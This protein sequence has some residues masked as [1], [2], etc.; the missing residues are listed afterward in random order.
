MNQK[1]YNE[2]MAR[3]KARQGATIGQRV[4][5]D[6][7]NIGPIEEF[8]RGIGRG[9]VKSAAA[10]GPGLIDL[11]Y[12]QMGAAGNKVQSK[13]AELLG[14][15]PEEPVYNKDRTPS[16]FSP[17]G[18]SR[19]ILEKTDK[20]TDSGFLKGSD[21]V[22]K[23]AFGEGNAGVKDPQW[24]IGNL[25]EMAPATVTIAG[26]TRRAITRNGQKHLATLGSRTATEAAKKKAKKEIQ[27]I[28]RNAAIGSSVVL[29][30]AMQHDEYRKWEKE[31]PESATAIGDAVATMFGA[32]SGILEGIG[33]GMIMSFPFI[34]KFGKTAGPKASANFWKEFAKAAPRS[35]AIEGGTE[36][37]QQIIQNIGKGLGYDFDTEITEGI[38]E[39][40]ILGAAVGGVFSGFEAQQA[41]SPKSQTEAD[42]MRVNKA[43]NRLKTVKKDIAKY[44]AALDKAKP[45]SWAHTRAE[46][47]MDRALAELTKQE[48]I[49]ERVAKR[50]KSED[51]IDTTMPTDEEAFGTTVDPSLTIEEVAEGIDEG[52]ISIEDW[53]K[54]P[55][56]KYTAEEIQI[57]DEHVADLKNQQD[58]DALARGEEVEAEV[59]MT[60]PGSTV[61]LDGTSNDSPFTQLPEEYT[62]EE[63]ID[64]IQKD[65]EIILEG[66]QDQIPN[67]SLSE[68][69]LPEPVQQLADLFGIRVVYTKLDAKPGAINPGGMKSLVD[70]KL[71]YINELSSKPEQFLFG[72]E[73][74]HSLEETNPAAYNAL[75]NAAVPMMKRSELDKYKGKLDKRG[76][77]ITTDRDAAKEMLG[78][79]V[80]DKFSDRKFWDKVYKQNPSKFKQIINSIREF[81]AKIAANF[82]GVSP[83]SD[84]FYNDIMALEGV[85]VDVLNEHVGYT[86]AVEAVSNSSVQ[87]GEATDQNL[88]NKHL[89]H[90]KIGENGQILMREDK[91]TI[92]ITRLARAGARTVGDISNTL[93]KEGKGAP[94]AVLNELKKY[95][96]STGKKI[97]VKAEGHPYFTKQGFEQDGSSMVW[98]AK[99][100]EG[101]GEVAADT[102]VAAEK[103]AKAEAPVSKKDAEIAR[104]MDEAELLKSNR[105]IRELNKKI[106][107]ELEVAR[108]GNK[109]EIA[110]A[111]EQHDKFA[112]RKKELETRVAEIETKR[113]ADDKQAREQVSRDRQKRE[114][115]ARDARDAAKGKKADR[116]NRNKQSKKKETGESIAEA[117]S[118]S[119]GSTVT[120]TGKQGG[121]GPV[122]DTFLFNVTANGK[123]ATFSVQELTNKAV[124]EAAIAKQEEFAAKKDTRTLSEKVKGVKR[125]EGYKETGGVTAEL[126]RIVDSLADA[127]K[128]GDMAAFA[129][130][131]ADSP[132]EMNIASE[133]IAFANAVAKHMFAGEPNDG[134]PAVKKIPEGVKGK[135]TK[136]RPKRTKEEQ[137]KLNVLT[138]EL[139]SSKHVERKDINQKD[140]D[141][142]KKEVDL[143]I[144]DIDN[145]KTFN[146]EMEDE[147]TTLMD[148]L[149]FSLDKKRKDPSFKKWFKGGVVKTGTWDG[150]E[151][152]M[153]YHGA[154][155]DRQNWTKDE[156]AF[157]F[158]TSPAISDVYSAMFTNRYD[159]LS[160]GPDNPDF[161]GMAD[162]LMVDYGY[163]G[164]A[165]GTGAKTVPAY[166]NI[167]NPLVL[168]YPIG[169][170]DNVWGDDSVIKMARDRGNDGI[171]SID[172]ES[173]HLDEAHS[174]SPEAAEANL[175][176]DEDYERGYVI[177]NDHEVSTE[178][179]LKAF[180]ES[181]TNDL[182]RTQTSNHVVIV[183]DPKKVRPAFDKELKFSLDP[184]KE[185]SNA[186]ERFEKKRKEFKKNQKKVS[187]DDP[188]AVQKV[189]STH[190][191]PE[192]NIQKFASGRA[193]WLDKNPMAG[194]VSEDF[195]SDFADREHLTTDQETDAKF[196]QYKWVRSET[197]PNA[198]MKAVADFFGVKIVPYDILPESDMKYSG[199]SIQ[200]HED[201]VYL[202]SNIVNNE[203]GMHVFGHEFLHNLSRSDHEAYKEFR[204]E[205]VKY[206]TV[207]ELID[208]REHRSD[209]ETLDIDR[210]MDEI[211]ADKAGDL[212]ID[213]KFWDKLNKS[214][215]S[216]F[217]KI[218]NVLK[219]LLTAFRHS[220]HWGPLPELNEFTELEDMLI[221]LINEHIGY[222]GAALD[223]VKSVNG[224]EA[225]VD[226]L[227][228]DEYNDQSWT[229]IYLEKGRSRIVIRETEA[230]VRVDMSN[231]YGGIHILDSAI[232][233]LKRYGV[234]NNK[235]IIGHDGS[236]IDIPEEIIMELNKIMTDL[237][238][239]KPQFS[240][241]EKV[242][243]NESFVNPIKQK[244]EDLKLSTKL[245][246]SLPAGDWDK[247][248]RGMARK[249]RINYEEYEYSYLPEWLSEQ[250][251][252]VSREDVLNY[253]TENAPKV[254]VN[255]KSAAGVAD[256]QVRDLFMDGLGGDTK[257][258]KRAVYIST[259]EVQRNLRQSNIFDPALSERP[260]DLA[261]E[262][263]DRFAGMKDAT[264]EQRL[265]MFR[266]DVIGNK[267]YDAMV[268]RYKS[269]AENAIDTSQ[270]MQA[271]RTES[272]QEHI[273][274]GVDE[275][276]AEDMAERAAEAWYENEHGEYFDHDE[277]S[278]FTYDN[279]ILH[280][281]LGRYNETLINYHS[282][283]GEYK[284]T[285]ESHWRENNVLSH[286]RYDSH[287]YGDGTALV[288][289]ENQ[290]DWQA[291][292][293]RDGKTR[294][295]PAEKL[296]K[297]LAPKIKK[298]LARPQIGNRAP[299]FSAEAR[300]DI[301]LAIF[302]HLIA[303]RRIS[304]KRGQFDKM[305]IPDNLR[306][307]VVDNYKGIAPT[308][309]NKTWINSF[310]IFKYNVNTFPESAKDLKD[311]HISSLLDKFRTI[312][313]VGSPSLLK[314]ENSLRKAVGEF[315]E[316]NRFA[317]YRKDA[318]E[319]P[320]DMTVG[321]PKAPYKKSWPLLGFKT[322]MIEAYKRGD[323]Y[324]AWPSTDKQV[325]KI[326]GWPRGRKFQSVIDKYIK[327]MP[328][329]VNE[330]VKKYGSKVEK[331]E[332]SGYE[333]YGVEITPKLEELV[334]GQQVP[335]FS[336]DEKKKYPYKSGLYKKYQGSP[337][338]IIDR[339]SKEW[340]PTT[341]INYAFWLTPDGT[342]LGSPYKQSV[343]DPS[344]P[345]HNEIGE[346]LKYE[347][348]DTIPS[349]L[350][351]DS[352]LSHF[353]DATGAIRVQTH[354]SDVLKYITVDRQPTNRQWATINRHYDGHLIAD[355]STHPEEFID[356]KEA[357]SGNISQVKRGINETLNNNDVIGN[358][359]NF[360]PTMPQFSLDDPK[361]KYDRSEFEILNAA[362]KTWKPT[363]DPKIALWVTPN[364]D[365]LTSP[366][367]DAY[368]PH[369]E[370]VKDMNFINGTPVKFMFPF[371]LTPAWTIF[372]DAT[373]SVRVHP[374]KH[375]VFETIAVGH[376]KITSKQWGTLSRNTDKNSKIALG[377]SVH[378]DLDTID[379]KEGLLFSEVRNEIKRILDDKSN[380]VNPRSHKLDIENSLSTM[381]NHY[382]DVSHGDDWLSKNFDMTIGELKE[383]IE[384]TKNDN[385]ELIN[386]PINKNDLPN[387]KGGMLTD[388]VLGGLPQ[389]S[390]DEKLD[391]KDPHDRVQKSIDEHGEPES[392]PWF[393][394]VKDRITA[395]W[396]SSTSMIPMI[397]PG[398]L[399]YFKDRVR[400]AR[401]IDK[402]GAQQAYFR[403]YNI[404]GKLSDDE[405]QVFTMN[406]VLNDMLNDTKPD[407]EGNAILRDGHLP[408]GFKT[409]NEIRES[410][411]HFRAQ[412]KKSPRVMN[413]LARRRESMLKIQKELID[414]GYLDDSLRGNDSYFHHETIRKMVEDDS[415][416]F[417]SG[418]PRMETDNLKM[419]M[420]RGG[421]IKAYSLNYITSEFSMI[422]NAVATLELDKIRKQIRSVYDIKQQLVKRA[423][424]GDIIV[425]EGYRKVY[426]SKMP[427]WGAR[428]KFPDMLTKELIAKEKL[429]REVLEKIA[430]ATE[431][432]GKGKDYWVLP[433]KVADAMESVREV[434]DT[435]IQ[436]K[437]SESVIQTW[438][439]WKLLNPF[440]VFRY[441]V[442]N[443][444]GDVDIALAY[445]W[446]I[447][448]Y[449]PQAMKDIAGDINNMGMRLP[450][451][452]QRYGAYLTPEVK[453]EMKEAHRTGVIG[454]G[455]VMHEVTNI[456]KEFEALIRG[457]QGGSLAKFGK[458]WWQNSKD[459]T[460]Y[461]ENLLRLATYRYFKDRIKTGEKHIYGA[462]NPKEIDEIRNPDE[463]AAKLSR[464]LIGDYGRLSENGEWMRKHLI[465]FYSWMEI[466]A[467]RYVRM[468]RNL[469]HEGKSRKGAA[470]SSLGWKGSVL[471]AKMLMFTGMVTLWN[472]MMFGDDEKEL[473]GFQKRQSHLLL[474]RRQDGSIRY[475]PMSGAFRD[476]LSWFDGDDA[477]YDLKDIESGEST[478]AQKLREAYMAPVWKAYHGARPFFRTGV[479]TAAG[480]TLFPGNEPRPIRDKMDYVSK[481]LS[482]EMAYRAAAGKPTRGIAKEFSNKLVT[483]VDPGES[484]YHAIREKVRHYNK[485]VGKAEFKSQPTS[486]SNALY[487]YKE[488]VKYG[489]LEA[490]SKYWL[491]YL[492]MGGSMKGLKKS[493]KLAR[494]TGGLRRKDKRGFYKTLTQD[495]KVLLNTASKWYRQT[496]SRLPSKR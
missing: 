479:E 122:P 403:I 396:K 460:N 152:A 457:P 358:D 412:A 44:Q 4:V 181:L 281:G 116:S 75:L 55:K 215:P 8:S 224:K 307:L 132:I 202:K 50:I 189:L 160:I 69:P 97:S 278:G 92:Y 269:E 188:A 482:L 385:I 6:D 484:A 342:L 230:A 208:Y 492:D 301:A 359:R 30:G 203:K 49:I 392:R 443:M 42:E 259:M 367:G 151:P 402:Y 275:I 17:I 439:K 172:G 74:S 175:F 205:A 185:Q 425:P 350:G 72:H 45:E 113:K 332:V 473:K 422:S 383:K 214:N 220:G 210:T 446:R 420:D 486:K 316:N 124:K 461:R 136:R 495:D 1:E 254:I 274:N 159:D 150:S 108:V 200:G 110:F 81:V 191:I 468:M 261:N 255:H 294:T 435:K 100:K 431:K 246:K 80:G 436:A 243:G 459:A 226:Y 310:N 257:A 335:Q 245:P 325:S 300:G 237:D 393:R 219:N 391:A 129:Q 434:K 416:L 53:Q 164:E 156:T 427:G 370:I 118:K 207:Q 201:I 71:V 105:E 82:T 377:V 64:A 472:N 387:N 28:S 360:D 433:D 234:K 361:L 79:F 464:E 192:I 258:L 286:L 329:Q 18:I 292:L 455:F 56:E 2:L 384:N 177:I 43:R 326:E 451:N 209:K 445:D 222:R 487:W 333:M 438:K 249:G 138:A 98:E 31:N 16:K 315:R 99:P 407:K 317:A 483:N 196:A 298:D 184:K 354:G 265:N 166:T 327:T 46:K 12:R 465:P 117:V 394:G 271:I 268:R 10:I 19:K 428:P 409:V 238:S 389:F 7:V 89:T 331:I 194:S 288:V 319:L 144:N 478:P 345:S 233:T 147:P 496:Y 285:G 25:A 415:Y 313:S 458:R 59:P 126:D 349:D 404:I 125:E 267:V 250:E 153:L 183:I 469:K 494:P 417:N 78:D 87:T 302:D 480:F 284:G 146:A 107:A 96:E 73:W 61:V 190:P 418:N 106:K 430:K 213:P 180:Q 252:K 474:G 139:T 334:K 340:E 40:F 140:I 217:Q 304:L 236:E 305:E 123:E 90:I 112:A 37:G 312:A 253:L 450:F 320:F 490:A 104:R 321:H 170:F 343:K 176:N 228:S 397:R 476:A 36:V 68:K 273:R 283:G 34:K 463:K 218:V 379:S 296:L 179:V 299:Y 306:K 297:E 11:A 66:D 143:R 365:M 225:D 289:Y 376:K 452:M 400:L 368:V 65:M 382:N 227:F 363:H 197:I 291:D 148:T 454:A 127:G 77:Q 309:A 84:A 173:I 171:I 408:H 295:I 311:R 344:R 38:A 23:S 381:L 169:Y 366:T 57:V 282:P 193:R 114:K 163:K 135:K 475:L 41:K 466:N 86:G 35:M 328:R 231:S 22:R 352:W 437:V 481:M 442:N 324:V 369:G 232:S 485:K 477:F 51:N 48:S 119:T 211:L 337:K 424:G 338:E 348:G 24:W 244:I 32:S 154:T 471:G 83:E 242:K 5:N 280:G 223:L 165:F 120:F 489:D 429:N 339:V 287:Q 449:L 67:I 62:D 88:G 131:I 174:M 260:K 414:K 470:I 347:N 256:K 93:T 221:N 276:T 187:M 453:A 115:E 94:T 399:G 9:A 91:G 13:T 264:T 440:S 27:K 491:S 109:E 419:A 155:K 20:I 54:S 14:L 182:D 229:R 421:S 323:S 47:G 142:I 362:S 15:P 270:Q 33:M 322:A 216:V 406:I 488:A 76:S 137:I 178:K 128:Q 149:K 263:V 308:T 198:Y 372:A 186:R 371:G 356:A 341:D 423:K 85:L 413:A 141:R 357:A 262:L 353:M 3:K 395:T 351:E 266:Q 235:S 26:I 290:S 493:I 199:L 375:G 145:E 426:T 373:G 448:Q 195:D 134:T 444:S 130:A 133:E 378:P 70:P 161:V 318:G 447:M 102:T 277:A 401:E 29:E 167:S 251:G 52:T 380:Q 303:N 157:H 314:F 240:L 279:M 293:S 462:S 63:A 206:L 456:S 39:S 388:D 58:I 103:P 390:L 411:I 247:I 60:P 21:S 162:N 248:L 272:Y 410:L 441:N 158:G 364:G 336:L 101:T 346:D 355:I 398:E 111:K 432:K 168:Y 405:R 386:G 241:D 330:F 374:N 467:P 95:A 212:F 239:G 121:F 204:R